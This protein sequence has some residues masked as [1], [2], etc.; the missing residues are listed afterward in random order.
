[1]TSAKR[2]VGF[3]C[4]G[5]GEFLKFSEPLIAPAE[6]AWGHCVEVRKEVT[7]DNSLM[8][9]ACVILAKAVSL[10]DAGIVFGAI[11]IHDPRMH[12]E[13]GDIRLG[14]CKWSGRVELIEE[15]T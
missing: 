9:V 1:M 11:G 3:I 10:S 2:Y 13:A 5:C 4:G 14:D 15:G 8:P 12:G 7:P 6:G